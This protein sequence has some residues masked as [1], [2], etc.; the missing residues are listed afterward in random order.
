MAPLAQTG[1]QRLRRRNA[2]TLQRR[3]D[4]IAACANA[5][6]AADGIYVI[7]CAA[8][9]LGSAR[10]IRSIRYIYIYRI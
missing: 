7:Y 4:A 6:A 10:S 8:R 2:K 1:Q 5:T 3:P 9:S